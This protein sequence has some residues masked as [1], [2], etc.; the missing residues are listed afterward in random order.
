MNESNG[1]LSTGR[2]MGTGLPPNP[3]IS[4]NEKKRLSPKIPSLKNENNITLSSTFANQA[5]CF[6]PCF[7]WK[8]STRKHSSCIA[9]HLTFT[10]EYC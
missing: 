5:I 4:I 1:T 8:L 6:L 9:E 3:I 7:L 2:D 10:N